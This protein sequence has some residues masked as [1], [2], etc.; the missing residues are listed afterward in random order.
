MGGKRTGESAYP[1]TVGPTQRFTVR[2]LAM[3]EIDEYLRH[4]LAVDAGS[5]V[6]GAAHS[7]PYGASDPFDLQE[8]RAREVTRWSTEIDD[9]G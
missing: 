1:R 7:H 4:M 5:G 3:S 8:G 6:D 2:P 9:V